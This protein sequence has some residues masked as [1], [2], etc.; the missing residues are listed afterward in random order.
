MFHSPPLIKPM[1]IVA[2][3]IVL[4]GIY[5]QYWIMTYLVL[6]TLALY[7]S[8]TDEFVGDDAA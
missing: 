4:A 8:F 3:P 6:R 2:T 5:L 7:I 1:L